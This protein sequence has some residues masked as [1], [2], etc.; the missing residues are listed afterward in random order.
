MKFPLNVDVHCTDG[1][2]GRSTHIILNPIT[3]KVMH[4][5]VKEQEAPYAERIVPVKWVHETTPELILLSHTKDEVAT[6]DIFNQENFIQREV[7]HYATDPEITQLWPYVV[8][9]TRII[10]EKHLQVPSGGLAVRRW[11]RVKATDGDIGQVDEFIVDPES[12]QVTHLVLKEGLPWKKRQI[13]IPVSEIERIENYTVYLKIH[14]QA[15]RALPTVKR[16]R[17]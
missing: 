15:V 17:K 9:A 8:P 14:K 3:E 11:A 10:S 1:L 5:V 4:I 12:K 16:R 13:T 6:L 7:P 2:C